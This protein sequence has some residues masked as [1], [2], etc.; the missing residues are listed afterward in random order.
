MKK[1]FVLLASFIFNSLIALP[2]GNTGTMDSQAGF[3]G[4]YVFNRRLMLTHS[5]SEVPKTEIYTNGG[6][7]SYAPTERLQVDIGLGATDFK[8]NT[9]LSKISL[10]NL[11]NENIFIDTETS[12]SYSLGLR[13]LAFTLRNINVGV[14][15]EYFSARPKVNT[16]T[17]QVFDQ[18]LHP[19]SRL[20]YQELQLG[21][22]ISYPLKVIDFATLIPY[23]GIK[24]SNVHAT[25]SDTLVSISGVDVPF[26]NLDLKQDRVIGYAI[27]ATLFNSRTWNFTAEGRFADEM[28]FSLMTNLIF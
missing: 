5:D 22:A 4:N 21:C 2:I 24:F 10:E 7:L 6:L 23:A 16:L 8:F 13:A 19:D 25:F 17:D 28:A 3:W 1:L 11:G 14:Q 15:A 9:H 26:S 27:G 20:K 12:F 18:I